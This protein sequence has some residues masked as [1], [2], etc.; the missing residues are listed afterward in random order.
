MN[1]FKP[2]IISKGNEPIFKASQLVCPIKSLFFVNYN[3]NVGSLTCMQSFI[4]QYKGNAYLPFY[5]SNSNRS[6]I[7]ILSFS[8]LTIATHS[9]CLQYIMKLAIDKKKMD[10]SASRTSFRQVNII[11]QLIDM[12]LH[13][14][15]VPQ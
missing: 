7:I 8:K 10:V 13:K 2:I 4:F 9:L 6:T 11:N 5:N 14:Y 12:T 15:P 1:F 3:V